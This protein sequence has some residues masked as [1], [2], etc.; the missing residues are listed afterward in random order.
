MK[1]S[2]DQVRYCGR[3]D[4][5]VLFELLLLSLVDTWNNLWSSSTDTCSF[6][7]S[8]PFHSPVRC[9]HWVLVLE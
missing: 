5:K 9:F 1:D 3:T 6:P 7:V 8:V 4:L 2:C